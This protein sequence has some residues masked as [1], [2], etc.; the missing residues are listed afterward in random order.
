MKKLFIQNLC[1]LIVQ[2][3]F[4]SVVCVWVGGGRCVFEDK[5]LPSPQLSF[6]LPGTRSPL[7]GYHGFCSSI[8][9]T[10]PNGD[11]TS[12]KESF[13]VSLTMS[14]PFIFYYTHL[15]LNFQCVYLMIWLTAV[16]PPHTP[17]LTSWSLGLCLL[18]CDTVVLCMTIIL[19]AHENMR[20]INTVPIASET[21]NWKPDLADWARLFEIMP[22][23]SPQFLITYSCPSLHTSPCVHFSRRVSQTV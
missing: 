12:S 22:E 21:E 13:L 7:L 17:T 11:I 1:H 20:R 5:H 6:L 10:L 2:L 23:K 3:P 16:T 8:S 14:G 15:C 4:F 18:L 9:V 19:N